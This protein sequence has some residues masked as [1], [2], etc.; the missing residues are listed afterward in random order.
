MKI[1]VT[2]RH[3]S[4]LMP[5]KRCNSYAGI[6]HAYSATSLIIWWDFTPKV[7]YIIILV[8]CVCVFVC[9]CV[10]VCLSVCPTWDIQN[11]RSYCHA[12]YTILKSFDW[13]VAQPAFRAYTTHGLREK[14]FGIIFA[15]YARISVHAPLHFRLLWAGWILPTTWHL[16]NH[17]SKVTLRRTRPLHHSYHSCYYRYT[18]KYVYF[19][20]RRAVRVKKT[21]E[22][23][24]SDAL[25]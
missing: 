16:L 3:S 12:A 9:R 24:A 19:P 1:G 18:A 11:G 25:N 4:F 23:F 5:A 22:V 15:S 13:R 7:S 10:C 14:A 17:F 8:F 20:K 21:W 6:L 2:C